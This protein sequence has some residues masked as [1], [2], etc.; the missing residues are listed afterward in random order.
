MV[1]SSHSKDDIS[2]SSRKKIADEELRIIMK[3]AEGHKK[4]LTALAKC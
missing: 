1:K 4:T 3:I 2:D